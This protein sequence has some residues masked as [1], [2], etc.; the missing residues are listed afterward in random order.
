MEMCWIEAAVAS[1]RFKTCFPLVFPCPLKW[2]WQFLLHF[3]TVHFHMRDKCLA[4]SRPVTMNKDINAMWQSPR[5]AAKAGCL[6]SANTNSEGTRKQVRP[7]H[8][9]SLPP[10]S[11]TRFTHPFLVSSSLRSLAKAATEDRWCDSICPLA[12]TVY[13]CIITSCNA[14]ALLISRKALRESK[15]VSATLY[16]QSST[17][18]QTEMF[19]II[20][21]TFVMKLWSLLILWA[22]I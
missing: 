11:I 14:H 13:G 16:S 8:N 4:Q 1:Y 18:G 21:V 6:P 2:D 9:Q 12:F 7:L 10:W 17:L 3:L 19:M 15:A 5:R 22:L 20:F